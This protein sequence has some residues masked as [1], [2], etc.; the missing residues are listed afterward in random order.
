MLFNL[1]VNL[2]SNGN[3]E[4]NLSTPQTDDIPEGINSH[5]NFK[6]IFENLKQVFPKRDPEELTTV[7]L[8]NV[9]VHDAINEIL[10]SVLDENPSSGR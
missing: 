4:L 3:E 5:A 7:A 1:H 10:D 2:G 6:V 8:K 9:N